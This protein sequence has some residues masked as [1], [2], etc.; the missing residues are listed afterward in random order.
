M[1]RQETGVAPAPVLWQRDLLLRQAIAVIP[2][3]WL[4]RLPIAWP[5]TTVLFVLLAIPALVGQMLEAR[6]ID[7]LAMGDAERRNQD[8]TR[9]VSDMLV[10]ETTQLQSR[11]AALAGSGGFAREFARMRARPWS[12]REAWHADLRERHGT[13]LLHA[14]DAKGN[15]LFGAG[16][17]PAS[18]DADPRRAAARAMRGTPVVIA[19]PSATAM[20]VSAWAPVLHKGE[21]IGALSAAIR[22][23]DALARTLAAASGAQIALASADGV[24]S[25]SQPAARQRIPRERV[26]HA[27]MSQTPGFAH[28]SG[29]A[30]ITAY[31]P[32]VIAGEKVVLIT[33]L[34]NLPSAQP[35]SAVADHAALFAALALMVLV[36]LGFMCSRSRAGAAWAW[37]GTART[38][39]LRRRDLALVTDAQACR[40]PIPAPAASAPDTPLNESAVAAD[41]PPSMRRTDDESEQGFRLFADSM[42]DQVF[43]T[44]PEN[45]RVYYVNPATEHIWGLTPEQVIANP[46][47]IMSMIHADDLE[48][49]EVRQR[50]EQAL[51]PVYIEFRIA[52]ASR[53]Q[54]WLSLQTQAVRLHNGQIRVHGICKDVTQHRIQQEALTQAKDE[55]EAASLA[56]SQFLANMSHEIRTPMNGVLGMTELLLGT[57]M[58]D[59]QRRFAET[60]YRSGQALLSIIND[61]L[62]FSKIEAGKLELVE[63]EFELA[64]LIEEVAQL[65]APRAHQKRIELLHDVADAVPA[66]LK[67]D[68]G[69][70]RQVILNLAGN[71][72][73]FTEKGEVM[74]AVA[75]EGRA[76]DAD[77]T[78]R[79]HFSVRDTGIG[80]S[81][82]MQGRLFHEFEQGSN[83]TTKRY[84]GTGLGLAISQQLVHMMG[85]G[86]SVASRPE[87]G[88]TF[89]FSITLTLGSRLESAPLLANPSG[90]LIGR[91]VL[92]VEDNPTNLNILVHQLENWGIGCGAASGGAQ[93]LEMLEAAQSAGRPFEVALIDMKMPGM[94]GIELAERIRA[95][96]RVAAL[97]MLMLASSASDADE[98]RA[99]ACGIDTLIEKPVRQGELRRAIADALLARS[100]RSSATARQLTPLLAGRVLVVEDNPVNREIATTMLEKIGCVHEIA[101]NGRQALEILGNSAFD[102][103]LLDCQMPEMDGYETVRHIRAGG[104]AYGPLAVRSDVPVIALTANA[105]T[106]DRDKCLAAGF[107]DYLSKPFAEGE[108]RGIL[109][110]WLVDKPNPLN[111]APRRDDTL[112]LP[113]ARTGLLKVLAPD[114]GQAQAG[115]P[116]G[117]PALPACVPMGAN[118]AFQG[119]LLDAKVVG[120]LRAMDA[121]SPGLMERLVDAY[122]ASAPA[123]MAELRRAAASCDLRAARQ[124][125]HT[126][127]SC[128]A[129]LGALGASALFAG[130]EVAARSGASQ[131]LN[132]RLE[133]LETQFDGVSGAVKALKN[134]REETHETPAAIA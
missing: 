65:L 121:E 90:M 76:D 85:G 35:A 126:L 96:P 77:K 107:T 11:A 78:V 52:H 23:D 108:L 115:P 16:D 54:R 42:A 56:K 22:W 109:F 28:D 7:Y 41:T 58:D 63:E 84:G 33:E 113:M 43:I 129:N 87:R 100:G 38:L 2:Q 69:R 62:D 50:M 46:G 64:P 10:R 17:T 101:E 27:L 122:A 45:S 131:D 128:H 119:A 51:E 114:C 89:S 111:A 81:E 104:G 117:G 53:G 86:I 3:R 99:R 21:I 123:L 102:V 15:L 98:A 79:L 24:W 74:L 4:P 67:G 130:I 26:A 132:D 18:A 82:E 61:I 124:A 68:A 1:C 134:P 97:R 37:I 60:V 34:A 59:R 9:V 40:M 105:L 8:V 127:K 75:I 71:A 57:S 73:K 72:I 12:E 106:G 116:T 5:L 93:A 133:L 48:L 13:D 25:T 31:N 6:G 70:L 19:L 120:T 118:T 94:S 83:A 95:N 125:A 92:V 55:A 88:S 91:R 80:I 110:N 47:S 20:V 32:L 39:F 29:H 49:F 14:I 30:T 103:V 44:N 112:V 66:W 36:A